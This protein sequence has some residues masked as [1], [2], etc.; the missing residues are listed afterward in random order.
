[1]RRSEVIGEVKL[2]PWS[3]RLPPL[4]CLD[5]VRRSTGSAKT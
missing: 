5:A 1:M 2:L 4:G 3:H